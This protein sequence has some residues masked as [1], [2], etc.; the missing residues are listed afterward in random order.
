MQQGAFAA[1]YGGNGHHVIGIRG[2][3]HP[4]EKS[5]TRMAIARS[6][7]QF[8][9]PSRFENQPPPLK[10]RATATRQADASA[11]AGSSDRGFS[12]ILLYGRMGEGPPLHP[13]CIH[14]VLFAQVMSDADRARKSYH[15]RRGK[16]RVARRNF[17]G[18]V[19]F[20][21]DP[22]LT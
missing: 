1:D 5:S 14:D 6:F 10:R 16:S 3:P 21:H 7:I 18:C 17:G 2:V 20:S 4:Q 8:L 22:R 13:G 15:Q 11:V 19:H 12:S 9:R